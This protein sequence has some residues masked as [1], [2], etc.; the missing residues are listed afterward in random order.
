[1]EFYNYPSLGKCKICS[2]IIS[3]ILTVSPYIHEYSRNDLFKC[4]ILSGKK[5]NDL[6][7]V[8]IFLQKTTGYCSIKGTRDGLEA[9]NFYVILPFFTKWPYPVPVS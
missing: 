5:Q 2:E 3:I 8:S 7:K 1:M 4:K 9:V 6:I